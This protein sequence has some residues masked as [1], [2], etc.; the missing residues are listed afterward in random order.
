MCGWERGTEILKRC[1]SLWI[2][3][4]DNASLLAYSNYMWFLDVWMILV[5]SWQLNFFISS[6]VDAYVCWCASMSICL[7]PYAQWYAKLILR[8]FQVQGACV[9]RYIK[10]NH[11]RTWKKKSCFSFS[12]EPTPHHYSPTI[13]SCA[14]FWL[15]KVWINISFLCCSL[16]VSYSGHQERVTFCLESLS[17]LIN[18]LKRYSCLVLNLQ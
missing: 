1:I 13:F 4:H 14:M 2:L 18:L 6:R 16:W 3:Y 15:L 17:L 12:P 8:T 5:L 10:R 11:I 7:H 9:K